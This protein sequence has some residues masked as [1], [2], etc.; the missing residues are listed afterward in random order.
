[1]ATD[2]QIVHILPVAPMKSNYPMEFT[3]AAEK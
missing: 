3:G 1:M 2:T